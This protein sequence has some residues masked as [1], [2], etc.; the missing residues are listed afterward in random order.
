MCVLFWLV[1]DSLSSA[2]TLL[3][4]LA[5]DAATG[6]EERN[7]HPHHIC[8]PLDA[9]AKNIL[10]AALLDRTSRTAVTLPFL[11]RQCCAALAPSWPS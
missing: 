1:Q 8:L 5:L 7:C 9:D 10:G 3:R 11:W 6:G 4:A 2:P